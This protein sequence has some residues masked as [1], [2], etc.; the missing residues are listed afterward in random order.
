MI[1]A[2][3]LERMTNVKES[4]AGISLVGI[5][6]R[7]GI[8]EG[9][10]SRDDELEPENVTNSLSISKIY[11]LLFFTLFTAGIVLAALYELSRKQRKN[12]SQWWD[13]VR[14]SPHAALVLPP[15]CT[16]VTTS[17]VSVKSES[18][19]GFV[20]K[21][22][23]TLYRKMAKKLKVN[24]DITKKLTFH[25]EKLL[26][27]SKPIICFINCK[28]GGNQGKVVL[29]LLSKLLNPYQ[30]YDITKVDP[31]KVIE[32]FLV[33]PGLR[34]L[35][36]GG[37]GT[38]GWILESMEKI[39]EDRRPPLAVLPLGTGNDLARV[40]GWGGTADTGTLARLLEEIL[41][42]DW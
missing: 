28:S 42:S 41:Y 14:N 1:V 26:P 25:P 17:N 35:V 11:S 24:V 40:L 39:A 27:Y 38:A 6:G 32:N 34:V 21:A 23:K 18:I 3:I 16:E 37:D 12:D 5:L 31:S 36:A 33:F 29:E 30:V 19:S 7:M 9:G 8:A 4:F 2:T 15:D 20:K 10:G 22:T 13:R